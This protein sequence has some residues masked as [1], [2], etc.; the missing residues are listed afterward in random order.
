MQVFR[1]CIQ[2]FFLICRIIY[3]LSTGFLPL[4]SE[5]TK[6]W[7]TFY[8]KHLLHVLK[9]LLTLNITSRCFSISWVTQRCDS[10][11]VWNILWNPSSQFRACVS[12]GSV[13]SVLDIL[14]LLTFYFFWL[15]RHISHKV[16]KCFSQ[17]WLTEQEF[18]RTVEGYAD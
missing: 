6:W 3:S 15:I 8:G 14:C 11:H 2:H 18:Q 1:H 5:M 16:I 4:S 12:V 13:E 9:H 17:S 10:T 7:N